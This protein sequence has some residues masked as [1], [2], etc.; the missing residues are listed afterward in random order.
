MLN[1]I[2]NLSRQ[3]HIE[4]FFLATIILFYA[5]AL[6]LSSPMEILEG[7]KKIVLSRDV[8]ITDYFVI[9]GYGPAFFNSATVML[10]S[11]LM[12]KA[13]KLNFVG[14]S[15]ASVMIMG[16]FALFGKEP[17]NILP[18][19]IGTI[20]YS[21]VQGVKPGRYIYV[22]FLATGVSPIITEL[23]KILEFPLPINIDR[24]STRLNSSHL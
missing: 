14:M 2:K 18:I 24:K 21:K 23:V 17:L 1:K 20:I 16:G 22:G 7:F 10:I 11:Y 15:I 13:F 4:Y 19:I 3:K 6:T 12:I 9:G 8:L 5:V